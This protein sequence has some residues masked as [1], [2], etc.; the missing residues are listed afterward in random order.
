MAAEHI[1]VQ[2]ACP[3]LDV[4]VSGYYDWRSRP[5]S[6]RA[7]RHAWLTDLIVEVHRRARR[8]GRSLIAVRRSQSG[9]RPSHRAAD[10]RVWWRAARDSNPQPPD[11]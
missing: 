5:P 4:S 1:P 3:V 9:K 7:V 11:P 8:R 6:A 10:Q 2:V